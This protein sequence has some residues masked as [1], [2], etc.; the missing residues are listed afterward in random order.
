M[1]KSVR[2]ITRNGMNDAFAWQYVGWATEPHYKRRRGWGT[3]LGVRW[4]WVAD[5]TAEILIGR[6]LH[7][8]PKSIVK[9]TVEKA[10]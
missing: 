8:G 2:Y 6:R 3:P 10:K 9:I 7:G 4:F 5:R 1:K